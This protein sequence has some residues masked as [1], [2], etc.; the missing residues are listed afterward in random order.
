MKKP[1]MTKIEQIEHFQ[2]RVHRFSL[3]MPVGDFHHHHTS[4]IMYASRFKS[5]K[6]GYTLMVKM[7]LLPPSFFMPFTNSNFFKFQFFVSTQL[8]MAAGRKVMEVTRPSS[9]SDHRTSLFSNRNW[10]VFFWN[11]HLNQFKTEH[12]CVASQ[13]LGGSNSCFCT[14]FLH[15]HAHQ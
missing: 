12:F 3:L 6:N 1:N 11:A 9:G 8:Q 15:A 5:P 2:T 4:Y 10:G 14:N 13:L 7:G